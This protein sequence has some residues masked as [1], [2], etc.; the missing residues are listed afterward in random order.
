MGVK[1]SI[2]VG[3]GDAL[4]LLVQGKIVIEYYVEH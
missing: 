4:E 3:Y 2:A 1:K